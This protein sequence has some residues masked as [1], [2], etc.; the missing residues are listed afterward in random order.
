[1]CPQCGEVWIVC[2][3]STRVQYPAPRGG[4]LSVTLVYLV[5]SLLVFIPCLWPTPTRENRI[6]L[7]SFLMVYVDLHSHRYHVAE[8][9]YL[10]AMV[11]LRV[12]SADIAVRYSLRRADQWT[13]AP[14]HHSCLLTEFE[15]APFQNGAHIHGTSCNCLNSFP[16]QNTTH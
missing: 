5:N 10:A 16:K 11:S 3:S 14:A 7:V 12:R 13:K 9:G 15:P 6:S 8:V 1:M 2:P 4:A